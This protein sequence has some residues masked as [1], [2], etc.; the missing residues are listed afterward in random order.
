MAQR[1]KGARRGE[2]REESAE[3]C[4]RI[5][6]IGVGVGMRGRMDVEVMTCGEG[7][8][9]HPSGVWEKER[10]KKF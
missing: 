1:I 10:G 3:V 7:E 6:E 2:G 4:E 5:V 8:R 9:Q